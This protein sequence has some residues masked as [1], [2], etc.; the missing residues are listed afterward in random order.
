MEADH[1][2]ELEEVLGPA[3]LAAG[4]ELGSGEIL[5]VFVVS[6]DLN[7]ITGAFQV[8][9]PL[10]KHFIDRE[11]LFVMSIIIELGRSEGAG[12]E[13]DR[14]EV[15][16]IAVDGEYRGKSI[17]ECISF[18]DDFGVG[19]PVSEYRSGGEGL[20]ESFESGPTCGVKVPWDIFAG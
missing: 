6:E 13:R 12:V 20:L 19:Y 7:R 11:E 10:F 5:Q 16:I 4:E 17:I 1:E 14:V 2:I 8:A 9:A 3:G 15:A 18:N